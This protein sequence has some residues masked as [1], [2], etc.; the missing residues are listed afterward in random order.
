MLTGL[1]SL[2]GWAGPGG[3]ASEM[4]HSL[5]GYQESV[6]PRPIQWLE[7]LPDVASS[8]LQREWSKTEQGTTYLW[9]ILRS[10]LPLFLAYLWTTHPPWYNTEDPCQRMWVSGVSGGFERILLLRYQIPVYLYL[11][12]FLFPCDTLIKE[13]KSQTSKHERIPLKMLDFGGGGVY[14]LFLYFLKLPIRIDGPCFADS[15]IPST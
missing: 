10:C 11:C 3:S 8:F 1:C 4:T 14:S 6:A 2:E 9:F 5:G 13:F 12:N 15:F 7:C